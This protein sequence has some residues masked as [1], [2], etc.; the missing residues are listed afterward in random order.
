VP[1]FGE[2]KVKNSEK[3]LSLG[4]VLWPSAKKSVFKNSSKY[5]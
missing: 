2:K 1:K 5:Y 4:L 3:W